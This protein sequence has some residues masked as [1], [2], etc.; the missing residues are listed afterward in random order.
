[1]G[2]PSM[3]SIRFAALAIPFVISGL[4]GSAIVQ[5]ADAFAELKDQN[6][7]PFE[8][9][10]GVV[11]LI[12]VVGDRSVSKPT[13]DWA[14]ALEAK[15]PSSCQV[16]RLLDLSG[17]TRAAA[18]L[19]R[20]GIRKQVGEKKIRVYLDW[21][22]VVAARFKIPVDEAVIVCLDERGLVLRIVKGE[23]STEKFDLVTE[24]YRDRSIGSPENK[25]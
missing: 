19:V 3:N 18:P 10:E 17:L 9:V 15:L 8:R 5:S 2:L 12:F 20:R 23:M 11:F 7:V 25:S 13:Q 6:S 21:K 4:G 24:I 16:V 14:D 22:G 1:M